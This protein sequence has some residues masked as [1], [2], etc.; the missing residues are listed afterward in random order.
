MTPP[1]SAILLMLQEY[2]SSV[3]ASAAPRRTVIAAFR[4]ARATVTFSDGSGSR[5]TA[6]STCG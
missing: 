2:G 3:R 5:S 4:R 6:S 1:N